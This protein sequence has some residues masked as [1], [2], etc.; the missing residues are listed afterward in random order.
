MAAHTVS[1]R[2]AG[3]TEREKEGAQ[4][5]SSHDGTERAAPALAR[6]VAE[7]RGVVVDDDVEKLRR[8]GYTDEEVGEVVAVVP[9]GIFTH[10][11]NHVVATE[12]DFPAAR[13]LAA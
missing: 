2:R 7:D 1:G 6:Q 8:A 13:D 11:F 10:G 12:V 9:L 4:C 3:L 5:A